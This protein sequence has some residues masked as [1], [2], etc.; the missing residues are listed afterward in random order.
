MKKEAIICVIIVILISFGH[1][2]LQGYSKDAIGD[3]TAELE[4]LKGIIEN[5]EQEKAKLKI[6]E[7]HA[8]WDKRYDKM[9]FYIEHNELEKVETELT[10]LRSSIETEEY[11]EAQNELARA[12]YLLKHIEEKNELSWKN[13]F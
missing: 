11:E 7:I 8:N 9:A 13:I 4:E 1:F 3:T 10:G 5:K 6:D 12:D 2:M